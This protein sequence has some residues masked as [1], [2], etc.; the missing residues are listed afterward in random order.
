MWFLMCRNECEIFLQS[1]FYSQLHKQNDYIL[2]FLMPIQHLL[3]RW[4]A[5]ESKL[6]TGTKS[7]THVKHQ[8]KLCSAYCGVPVRLMCHFNV[9]LFMINK[10]PT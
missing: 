1:A 3:N 2:F 6:A 5:E 8:L 9:V 4:T 10:S 7:G